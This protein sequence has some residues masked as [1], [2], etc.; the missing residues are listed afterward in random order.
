MSIRFAQRDAVK[1]DMKQDRP[2]C[3]VFLRVG[4]ADPCRSHPWS[5]VHI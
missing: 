1:H 4:K 3:H 5:L 2:R